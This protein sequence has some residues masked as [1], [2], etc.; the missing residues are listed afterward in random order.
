MV[1]YLDVIWLLNLLIDSILLVMTAV[2]LKRH[3]IWWRIFLGGFIGSLIVLFSFTPYA[4]ISG[5]PLMKLFFSMIMVFTAFGFKR[6]RFYLGN[7]LM[8]YFSTFLTGGILIGIHYFL[9]FDNSLQSSMFLA[10]VKGFGDPISWVF[11]MFALPASWYFARGRMNSI[12]TVKI[13]YDQLVDIQ[14]EMNGLNLQLKGLVDS[15]NQ[16]YDPLS[17]SPVMLVSTDKLEEIIPAEI[18]Q[19]SEDNDRFMSGDHSLPG[20]WEERVRFIPAQSIGK[21]S[22]LLIAYKP[23]SIKIRKGKETWICQKGLVVFQ[24]IVFS[25]DDTFNCIVHP[26]MLSSA[27]LQHVS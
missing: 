13:Q 12:E 2:F 11:V 18:L 10:S 24:N 27:P 4:Y 25:A 1:L 22:Q 14:I 20:K 5:H 16:L 3:L 15:G 6:F 23:D 21:K 17:K 7:L 19:L 8:L 26:R 9:R